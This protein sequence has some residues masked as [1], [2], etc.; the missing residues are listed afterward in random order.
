MGTSQRHIRLTLFRCHGTAF[1]ASIASGQT[2]STLHRMCPQ[3]VLAGPHRGSVGT[4]LAI[5]ETKF[6][7]R[8]RVHVDGA[9]EVALEYEDLCKIRS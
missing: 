3:A 6:R 4:L 7:A 2:T 5:E 1:G 8:V 9:P